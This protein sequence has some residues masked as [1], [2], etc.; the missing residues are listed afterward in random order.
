[1]VS[2]TMEKTLFIG[3]GLVIF[4]ILSVPIYNVVNGLLVIEQKNIA[5]HDL[6]DKIEAGIRIVE[7]NESIIYE[8]DFPMMDAMQL[9]TAENGWVLVASHDDTSLAATR[10]VRA[11][12]YP[13]LV[14]PSTSPSHG[15]LRV[16]LDACR[17][18]INI[19]RE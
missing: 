9:E 13:L 1:M 7:Y 14:V 5:F 12:R 4:S 11:W 17:I 2:T 15:M 10:M 16:F 6:V 3:L 8:V 19:P 18:L